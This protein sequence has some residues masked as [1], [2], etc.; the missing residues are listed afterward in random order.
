MNLSVSDEGI[1]VDNEM[2][3]NCPGVYAAGDVCSV[4]WSNACSPLWF[5]VSCYCGRLTHYFICVT[6]SR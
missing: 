3:T 5:Q 2:R 4:D 6:L 1:L